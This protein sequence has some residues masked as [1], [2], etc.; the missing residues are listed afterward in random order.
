MKNA[1]YVVEQ[2]KSDVDTLNMIEENLQI[3]AGVLPWTI[4]IH[5]GVGNLS[6]E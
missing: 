4:F 2:T 5:N 3:R 6:H 1:T